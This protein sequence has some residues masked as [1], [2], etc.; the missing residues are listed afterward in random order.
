M[1]FPGVDGELKHFWALD[2]IGATIS[3]AELIFVIGEDFAFSEVTN[4][5]LKIILRQ[6]SQ[7]SLLA[8]TNEINQNIVTFDIIMCDIVRMYGFQAFKDLIIDGN[9]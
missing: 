7:V 3:C 5:Y 9:I 8:I 1:V 6:V 4:G 2:W